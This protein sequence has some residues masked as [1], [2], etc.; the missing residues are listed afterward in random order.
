MPKNEPRVPDYIEVAIHQDFYY[1]SDLDLPTIVHEYERVEKILIDSHHLACITIQIENLTQ[2]E[3]Q[4]GS[5]VYQKVLKQIAE[6]ISDLQQR[7]FRQEDVFVVDL[8]DVN[9]FVLFLAAPREEKTTLL[10]H[11]E[12]L[13]ERARITIKN[14]IFDT[15]YPYFK[16]QSKPSVGYGLV[17]KNPMISN[18]RM[19]MQLVSQAKKMGEFMSQRQAY[20]SRQHLL[21]RQICSRSQRPG[22]I[23]PPV[24]HHR[25]RWTPLVDRGGSSTFDYRDH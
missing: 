9:T 7:E 13:A 14:R 25:K 20:R 21:H 12:S 24:W 16:L 17:V 6:I 5:T 8:L 4:Y 23:P 22:S 11:L 3:Y 1:N 19:I 10:D 2:I 18:M 15:M